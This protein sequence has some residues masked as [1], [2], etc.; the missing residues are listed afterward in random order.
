MGK[1]TIAVRKLALELSE[2]ITESLGLGPNH[3]QRKMEEG[4]QVIALNCYPPCPQPELAFGLPPHSDYSC[5]TIL[6]HSSEGLEIMDKEDGEWKVVPQQLDGALQV[7]I[8]D[9]F[10]VLSNGIYK[11]VVHRATLNSE[12]TRVSIASLHSLGMDDK[13][14]TATELVD[15]DHPKG[16]KGSSFKDFPNF[17]ASN[18]IGQ[19][20]SFLDSLNMDG[21]FFG[22]EPLC[23]GLWV[24]FVVGE[25]FF[26]VII[27]L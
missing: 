21:P 13:M 16:Y 14:E 24:V 9:H 25:K 17:L 12:R 1:Y 26:H 8:G 23:L 5:M 22:V 11:S 15:E 2:A 10:E 4:M 20:K 27:R 19:G 7:Y 3:L 18:E 6:L